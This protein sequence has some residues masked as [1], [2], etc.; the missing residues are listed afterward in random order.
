MS[1]LMVKL[2]NE[3]I[4]MFIKG[5][6]VKKTN[7]NFKRTV[8]LNTDLAPTPPLKQVPFGHGLMKSREDILTHL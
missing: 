6:E 1:K 2:G 4:K 8:N 3:K 5:A 7:N